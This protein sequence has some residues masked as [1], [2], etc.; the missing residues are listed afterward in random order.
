MAA[1]QRLASE[2]PGDLAPFSNRIK[3]L[4][5]DAVFAPQ[6]EHLALDHL[7][8][9]A[10]AAVVLEIDAGAGPVVLAQAMGSCRI[11]QAAQILGITST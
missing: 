3:T 5:D 7:A 6:R 2:A 9:G 10:I 11:A 8:G 1:R 4:A